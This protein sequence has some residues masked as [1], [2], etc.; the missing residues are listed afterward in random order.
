MSK[1]AIDWLTITKTEGEAGWKRFYKSYT[2]QSLSQPKR[3][4]DAVER[5]GHAAVFEAVVAASF[6]TLD[7][8]PLN[9]VLAIALSKFEDT[10]KGIDEADRYEFNLKRAKTRIEAQ[11]EELENKIEK[12]RE[13]RSGRDK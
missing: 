4:F 12:A 5:L 9:Y 7:G 2:G 8:D 13:I 3:F 6:R 1:S 11:N 10:I